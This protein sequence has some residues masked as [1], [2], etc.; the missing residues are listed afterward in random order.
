M[1]ESGADEAAAEVL[2]VVRVGSVS[3]DM[4]ESE[5]K[6]KRRNRSCRMEPLLRSALRLGLGL[7]QVGGLRPWP[8]GDKS[9]YEGASADIF[10]DQ[11]SNWSLGCMLHS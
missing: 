3:G 10:S 9:K 5:V 11:V 1:Q 2:D 4:G 6:L 7:E 8:Q